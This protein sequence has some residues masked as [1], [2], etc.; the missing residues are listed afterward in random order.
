MKATLI[1]KYELDVK[2]YQD[3]M[4]DSMTLEDVISDLLDDGELELNEIPITD[5]RLEMQEKFGMTKEEF[6]K[7]RTRI[8]SKMIE[9]PNGDGVFPTT[10]AYAELDDL[11]DRMNVHCYGSSKAQKMRS[12]GSKSTARRL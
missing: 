1:V 3:L 6:I 10:V 12:N 7:E 11:Y 8:I 9:N 2:D 4:S 5:W